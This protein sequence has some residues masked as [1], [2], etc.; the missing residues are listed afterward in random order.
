MSTEKVPVPAKNTHQVTSRTCTEEV[1]V[2]AKNT[3]RCCGH[4]ST[5]KGLWPVS[6]VPSYQLHVYW[7]GT[8]TG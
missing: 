5:D 4:N 2:P 1:P 6:E 8:S 7:G 3:H